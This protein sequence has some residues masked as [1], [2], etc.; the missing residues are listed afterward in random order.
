MATAVPSSGRHFSVWPLPT[1]LV[2]LLPGAGGRPSCVD[3]CLLCLP[4]RDPPRALSDLCRAGAGLQGP[5]GPEGETAETP[6]T[7]SGREGLLPL[8][9]Q[10]CGGGGRG[11]ESCLCPGPLP[12]YCEPW[13][14]REKWQSFSLP[15]FS[16]KD[17]A[18][19]AAHWRGGG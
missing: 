19:L 15:P 14:A 6:G 3:S 17:E 10:G 8:T 5:P 18:F 7:G 4:V 1:T 12:A 13:E 16:P 9:E 11:L 2:E